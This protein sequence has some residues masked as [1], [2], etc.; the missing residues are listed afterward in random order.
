MCEEKETGFGEPYKAPADRITL[1]KHAL[2]RFCL[3]E[4]TSA[5]RFFVIIYGSYAYGV[6]TPES[7][8]DIMFVA[9]HV[10]DERMRRCVAFVKHLHINH[11][12]PLDGELKY[13]HKVLVP[14]SFMNE[15]IHGAGFRDVDGTYHIPVIEK[16]RECLESTGLRKRFLLGLMAHKHIFVAGDIDW[17]AELC[18]IGQR[19]LATAI[20][21]ARGM[22]NVTSET[23]KELL[24]RNG[25]HT[26]DFYLGFKDIPSHHA[27][28]DVL[29]PRICAR[30]EQTDGNMMSLHKDAHFQLMDE[31]DLDELIQQEFLSQDNIDRVWD[32]LNAALKSG[33]DFKVRDRVI[34]HLP[35]E[36]LRRKICSPFPEEGKDLEEIIHEFQE[37]IMRHS[38]N[39][40]SK[41]FMAFPDSANSVAALAGSILSS[42]MNQ[43]LINSKHCAPAASVVEIN[44]I[45]WL[46]DL[47]GYRVDHDVKNIF[48]VGGIFV[49]GGVLA[50][51]TAMM[52]AREHA[53][54]STKSKGIS[55]SP[56][57][58]RVIVPKYL[59][60]YSIRASLGWLGLGEQNVIR[61]KTK[62]FKIDLK[63][64]ERILDEGKDKFVFMAIV[65]YAGDSRSMTIDNF[66]ALSE[67]AKKNGIWF[68]IDAC[69]G[70][71]CAFSDTLKTKLGAIHL[72]D[73]VTID[74]HKALFLPYNLS[75][76]LVK[77]PESFRKI[78]GTSD[79][80]MQEDYAFGQITPFIGSKAFW[81]LK[82][83]FMW[84]ALGRKNIGRLI[85]R[86][87]FLAVYLAD[88]ISGSKDLLLLNREVHINSVMFI[89]RPPHVRLNSAGLDE[90]VQN[91]NQLNMHIQETMFCEGDFY[92]HTFSIPDLGN[93]VGTGEKMLQALRYMGGNP[94]TQ[95]E[96]VDALIA[97]VREHGQNIADQ[98]FQSKAGVR[99]VFHN[100]VHERTHSAACSQTEGKS[101]SVGSRPG[102]VFSPLED[103]IRPVFVLGCPRSGTTLIG[104]FIATAPDLVS[105]GELSTMYFSC[106]VAESEYGRVPSQ[107]KQ[108]YLKG[109]RAYSEQFMRVLCAREMKVGFVEST[110][111]NLR[112]VSALTTSFPKAIFV[113]CIRHYAG[114]I[115]SM[116]NSWEA[117]YKWAGPSDNNRAHVWAEMNGY[118][119]QVPKERTIFFSY[120][121]M[122]QNPVAAISELENRLNAKGVNGPFDHSTFAISHGS[123]SVP[124]NVLFK[125]THG[126]SEMRSIAP[127]DVSAWSATDEDTVYHI[128]APAVAKIVN[129]AGIEIHRLHPT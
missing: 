25:K 82:L 96:D 15:A 120:D 31:A 127:Y 24:L 84:K 32:R 16:T 83:W 81:S 109:L 86:R 128:L 98:Y 80:I 126:E 67:I 70:F 10:D 88:L 3:E 20:I 79:L 75:A 59:E 4:F 65:A 11:G 94:L 7:D 54:P 106:G 69:H 36:S 111:W 28:L 37:N 14:K 8:L 105:V 63:D 112:V 72:S 6:A 129:V 41:N 12:M 21:L 43:N 17:Y 22:H 113:V 1:F 13:E 92:I 23:L 49:T 29:C 61:V 30:L 102:S 114:V 124:R 121:A 104:E 48:Q 34:E 91:L 122:C 123:P 90:Y 18:E 33:L 95:K 60:H 73:S 107:Y 46:R 53:F 19:N 55:F 47:I 116:R 115:Q 97:R 99:T 78:A 103:D 44:V 38:T 45:Q 66:A 58:V 5:D 101:D 40:S 2:E 52:M 100:Q 117:G 89:Y 56:T 93:V 57:R 64:L 62:D 50:N 76:V 9:D 35:V 110:P 71:Q 87:H 77:D 51:A 42:L 118:I 27:Y 125:Q 39:F 85:D 26:G 68:H 108:E 119:D 74:P